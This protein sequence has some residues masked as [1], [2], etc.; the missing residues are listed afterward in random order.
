MDIG[1]YVQIR[2]RRVRD[3]GTRPEG[4]GLFLPSA[5]LLAS[6]LGPPNFVARALPWAK[7]AA[8]DVHE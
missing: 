1:A 3:F 6:H 8:S 7:I 4:L 2:Q 5:A